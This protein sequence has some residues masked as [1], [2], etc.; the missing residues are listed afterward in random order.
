MEALLAVPEGVGEDEAAFRVSIDDFDGL[1]GHRG[2]DVPRALSVAVR[3][4][5]DEAED[6]DRVHLGLAGG[7]RAHDACDRGGPAHVGLHLLHPVRRLDGDA[8]GVKGHALADEGDRLGLGVLGA[9]PLDDGELAF[10]AAALP[11]AE[12]CAHTELL[13]LHLAE[14]LDRQAMSLQRLHAGREFYGVQDIGGFGH[15]VPG[16]GD[17]VRQSGE[18]RIGLGGGVRRRRLDDDLGHRRLRFRLFLGP[19][20]IKPVG[21]ET[22]AE[23]GLRGDVRGHIA[24][25]HDQSLEA[26]RGQRLPGGRSGGFGEGGG[27]LALGARADQQDAGGA[28]RRARDQFQRLALGARI[29]GRGDRPAKLSAQRLIQRRRRRG[30]RAFFQAQDRQSG[31]CE[32]R[33]AQGGEVDLHKKLPKRRDVLTG[34]IGDPRRV[35]KTSSQIPCEKPNATVGAASAPL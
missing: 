13:H 18:R 24:Q 12:Q 29:A 30:Q 9:H 25:T 20:T 32:G 4:V 35:G 21:G 11:D 10:P 33:G 8:A 19:V 3:H 23:G 17:G 27:D 16:K 14:D 5:L 2:D 28:V 26:S 6:A 1:A 7:E 22:D 15:E 34:D 31:T